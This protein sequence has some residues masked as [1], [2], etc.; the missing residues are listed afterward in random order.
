MLISNDG[1]AYVFGDSWFVEGQLRP[2]RPQYIAIRYTSA[3]C[4]S[5]HVVLLCSDGNAIGFDTILEMLEIPA[6]P[7]GRRY[8]YVACGERHTVLIRDE[9]VAVAFGENGFRQCVLQ[10]PGYSDG[11]YYIAAACGQSLS[12]LL[13]SDG[14]VSVA[15]LW[16][17]PSMI[18]CSGGFSAVTAGHHHVV[19]LRCDG[20]VEIYD[21]AI[22]DYSGALGGLA[23]IGGEVEME[24]LP[25]GVTIT[26]I[27]ADFHHSLILRSDGRAIAIGRDTHVPDLPSGMAYVDPRVFV[28][29]QW[30]PWV[31]RWIA[32][33]ILLK[34]QS[35]LPLVSFLR[36]NKE[37]FRCIADFL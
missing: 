28:P 33:M 35:H 7:P 31:R 13:R 1:S 32:F 34:S 15:G 24:D 26:S 17:G 37:L 2:P 12:F 10:D 16:T 14:Q 9:G 25:E 3:G 19:L 22:G 30:R 6:L 21:P 5:G 23:G 36:S 29:W 27:E 20:R 4:G 11:V 8:K 18:L